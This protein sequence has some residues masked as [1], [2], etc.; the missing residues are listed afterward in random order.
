MSMVRSIYNFN[1]CLETLRAGGGRNFMKLMCQQLYNKGKMNL[2]L[3]V[4]KNE[5][6]MCFTEDEDQISYIFIITVN[7]FV[8]SQLSVFI[9]V[10]K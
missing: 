2:N 4:N 1:E 6:K 7:Q 3:L 9:A 8:H 5:R 10:T